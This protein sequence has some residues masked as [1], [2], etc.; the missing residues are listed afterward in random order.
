MKSQSLKTLQQEALIKPWQLAANRLPQQCFQLKIPILLVLVYIIILPFR[1]FNYR[2]PTHLH[3]CPIW[4]TLKLLEQLFRFKLRY[5]KTT[6]QTVA[7]QLR[8]GQVALP[9]PDVIISS[10][11]INSVWSSI[12]TN[13]IWFRLWCGSS[14]SNANSH[15]PYGR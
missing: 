11:R 7:N 4:T 14:A 15:K 2:H 1:L 5:Y 6:N 10:H 3:P 8:N 12:N 9:V 13:L